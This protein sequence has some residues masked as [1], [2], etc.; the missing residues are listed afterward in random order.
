MAGGRPTDYTPDKA[1]LICERIA[2][3]ESVRKICL[4]DDMPKMATIFRWLAKYDEFREQYTRAR[5][6]QAETLFDEMVHI[7]DTPQVGQKSVSKATGLEITEADM[8]EHRRLQVE[9]RKW[10]LGKMA[11]KKYSDKF[12]LEHSGKD[13]GPI[14]VQ[15]TPLD[16][17]L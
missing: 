5:E 13:G 11:P 12:M 9:T 8:I 17:A 2:D 1:D 16:E 6:I 10:V 14:I 7:A 15:T 4:D 3:G